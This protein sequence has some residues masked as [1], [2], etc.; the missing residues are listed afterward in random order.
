MRRARLLA[1]AFEGIHTLAYFD[2][3]VLAA[4]KEAGLKGYWMGYFASRSAPMGAVTAATV[5]ATFPSFNPDRIRRAIPD[6]W[7]LATPD[8][9]LAARQAGM[10]R[11]LAEAWSDVDPDQLEDVATRAQD[12]AAG[13]DVP[14]ARSSLPLYAAN[15]AREWP[16]DPALVIF[17]ASTLV[18]EYRGDLHLALLAS[19]GIDGIEANVLAGAT[20][21]YSRDWIRESRGWGDEDWQGA[22]DRLVERG[23]I[24]PDEQLTTGGRA[25]RSE[26]ENHTDQLSAAPVER[27][28]EQAADALLG[29][30]E[31]LVAATIARLPDSAPQKG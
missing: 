27:I 31:P 21:A 25:W 11:A 7:S 19:S 30:L 1:R 17:H 15:A 6:A 20:P 8:E 13:I 24:T 28:G 10:G 9:V 29:D 12:V 23:W 16:D 2:P 5:E 18:R 3:E 22:V 14:G 26:L 4:W